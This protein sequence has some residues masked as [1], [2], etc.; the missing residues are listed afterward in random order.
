MYHDEDQPLFMG[1]PDP[2]VLA[3]WQNGLAKS[4][5]QESIHVDRPQAAVHRGAT[6]LCVENVRKKQPNYNWTDRQ[7]GRSRKEHLGDMLA[8]ERKPPAPS[9]TTTVITWD[10]PACP[11]AAT[12]D[13]C[14]RRNIDPAVKT[15]PN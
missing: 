4:T 11:V 15:N 10:V 13:T 2:T 9:R 14:S 7:N 6:R 3:Q 5:A 8:P 1:L 12:V